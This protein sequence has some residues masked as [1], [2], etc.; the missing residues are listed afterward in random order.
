MTESSRVV[1][2]EDEYFNIEDELA[3]TAR[4]R[5]FLRMRDQRSRV[6]A[7]DEVRR[8][9]ASVRDW[10]C[11]RL[12]DASS[13]AQIQVLRRELQEMSA[14]IQ[15]TR[16]EIAA[17]RLNDASNSPGSSRIVAASGELDA[18]VAQT[19]RASTEILNAA[20]RIITLSGTLPSEL[21][22]IANEFSAQATE[23]M[24]ACAFQDLTGQR[25]TKVVKTLQYLEQRVAAMIS[26]WGID[27]NVRAA[28]QE[29]EDSRPDAHLLNGPSL[30]GQGQSQA[31]IDELM[32]APTQAATAAPTNA[33][34]A[35]AKPTPV[36]PTKS[37]N[38]P[39]IDQAEIDKLFA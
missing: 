7:L 34:T 30:P 20:E 11:A 17:L 3:G 15:K 36:R 1:L 31:D 39:A 19:E 26:I 24:T 23:I 28:L 38:A 5:A 22:E 6:V 10:A 16:E 14:F 2:T 27:D 33:P 18:I 21:G 8:L 25:V 13:A 4:G 32:N 37:A 12:N 9:T 29:I 35:A